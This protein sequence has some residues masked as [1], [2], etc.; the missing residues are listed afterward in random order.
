MQHDSKFQNIHTN[1]ISIL[2]TYIA[3]KRI[4][5]KFDRS[6]LKRIVIELLNFVYH[7]RL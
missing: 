5:F 4:K 6:K 2:G 7:N 3:Q 1:N